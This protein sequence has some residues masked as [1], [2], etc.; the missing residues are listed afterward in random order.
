M[1]YIILLVLFAAFVWFADAV[2]QLGAY[3]FR[4]WDKSRSD[5][6]RGFND[7]WETAK[8]LYTGKLGLIIA[9]HENTIDGHNEIMVE[10]ADGNFARFRKVVE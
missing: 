1:E 6:N 5:F 7:G 3:A 9:D 2:A 10:Y 4:G 8:D